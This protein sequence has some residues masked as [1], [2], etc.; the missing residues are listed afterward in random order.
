[1]NLLSKKKFGFFKYDLIND[2][3]MKYAS[4]FVSTN[5]VFKLL[6]AFISTKDFK[7]SIINIF[8]QKGIIFII[9]F[10][11]ISKIST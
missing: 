6:E 11:Y 9:L 3:I 1:M 10:R 2:K 7:I 5:D 4:I 8:E